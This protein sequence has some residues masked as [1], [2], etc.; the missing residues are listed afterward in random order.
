MTITKII[1][2]AMITIFATA[3]FAATK[4]D[5]KSTIGRFANTNPAPSVKVQTAQTT[6]QSATR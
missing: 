3:S 6:T 1:T 2:A 5:Q 4:C